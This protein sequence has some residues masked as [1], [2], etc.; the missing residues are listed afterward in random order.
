MRLTAAGGSAGHRGRHQ[1][2]GHRPRRGDAGTAHDAGRAERSGIGHQLPLEPPDPWRPPLPGA[3]RLRPGAGGQPGAADPAGGSRPIWCGPCRSSFRCTA[4]D[5]ISRWRLAAGML[6]YDLLALFRNVRPHRMLGKRALL[7]A[8]PMLRDRGL[9]GGARYYDAQC[10]DARLVAGHGPLGD[11]PWRPGGQLHGGRRAGADRRPGRGRAA[12]G[13]ADRG[14]RASSGP[15]VVVNATGPWADRVRRL[16]DAG[17]APL[18]QPTKG[19]HVVVDRSPARPPRGDRLHQPDRRPGDVRAAL[20]RPV[21]HRH[22]R[23]RYRRAARR[24]ER[25]R[26]RHRLSAPLGQRP[27]PQRPAQRGGRAGSLGRAPAPAAGRRSPQAAS[28]P[29]ARAC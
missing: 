17:A 8:E 4:G 13:P 29:L 23:H 28:Q 26:R 24:A 1:R 20:G 9:L 25:H 2:G 14:A 18:L 11:P 21:L 15:S 16:E 27:F 7:E 12:G 22:H 6:L 10:D 3:G 19:V 5:R